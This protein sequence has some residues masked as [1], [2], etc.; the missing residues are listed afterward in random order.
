LP[1]IAPERGADRPPRDVPSIAPLPK[2]IEP[3]APAATAT[4]AAT[5][6]PPLIP[7]AWIKPAAIGGGALLLFLFF[8]RMLRGGRKHHGASGPRITS[9]V[10]SDGR[11]EQ[12]LAVKWK[13]R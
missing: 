13:G 7:A 9:R 6:A 1:S 5:P 4:P 3:V 10:V 12:K 8:G 2:P 11:A